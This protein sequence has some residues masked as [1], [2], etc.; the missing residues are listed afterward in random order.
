MAVFTWNILSM[1]AAPSLGAHDN[2]VMTANWRCVAKEGKYTLTT[3]NTARFKVNTEDF[4]PFPELTE[5]QVL[6]WC[7]ES[8]VDKEFVE[9]ML[10]GQIDAQ[11]KPAITPVP[12]PWVQ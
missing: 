1:E 7:W 2:V 12:L 3:G 4:T 8:Q 6:G 9:T 11:M 5:A 10:Q